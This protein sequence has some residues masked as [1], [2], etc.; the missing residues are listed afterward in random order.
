MSDSDIHA[1]AAAYALGAI[2]GAERSAFEAHLATCVG[3]R[4]EVGAYGGVLGALGSAAPMRKP[5][6]RLKERILTEV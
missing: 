1:D 4:R 2:E 6:G 3:C 5:P